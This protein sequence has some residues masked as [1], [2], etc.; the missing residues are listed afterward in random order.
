MFIFE[1]TKKEENFKNSRSKKID[2]LMIAI[3]VSIILDI[4]LLGIYGRTTFMTDFT[5]MF[6]GGYRIML[7][8]IPYQDFF[9]PIGPVSFAFLGLF[10][11]VFGPDILAS[12]LHSFF[13]V[14][15]LT[16]PFYFIVRKEFSIF[17][18]FIFSLFFYISFIG[19]S[20]HPLYNY[21][22]Y[23]FLFLNIFLILYHIKKDSLPMYVYILSAIL[24]TLDFYTKQD[25]GGIHL[26]LLFL[27][28]AVN[29]R[30]YWKKILCFYLIPSAMFVLGTFLILSNFEGFLYWYN[31]GQP[32]HATNF[33]KFFEPEKIVFIT[34][35]W[36]FYVGI[37]FIFL[38]LFGKIKNNYKKKIISL[39]LVI[40]ISHIVSNTLS[41]STRQLSVMGLPILIFFICLLLKD[42]VKELNP[43]NRSL[44][45]IAIILFLIVNVNPF[46]TYGL[47]AMNYL[48]PNLTRI[49]QGCFSGYLI[50]KE[51]ANGLQEIRSLIKEYPDFI[52]I[53]EDGFLYCDYKKEPPKKIPLCFREGT[54]F[55]MQDINYIAAQILSNNPQIILIQNHHGHENP[56][57]NN[58][59]FEIF[60][61]NGYEE[62][63][64]INKTSTSEAPIHIF[65]KKQ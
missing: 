41:G 26:F 23:F 52:S 63:Q 40:A 22:T 29:Y 15:T 6:E 53:T 21:T 50:T 12:M 30:K 39:F 62:R 59:F 32:P 35:S 1:E 37:I 19:L 7:G 18:S 45:N 48:N 33:S 28:F 46:P 44:F 49:N 25:T 58:K 51:A 10:Y 3:L 14:I 4:Q 31:Y 17:F 42:S 13:L 54:H 36:H 9:S 34:S 43:R 5:H 20:F 38:L 57:T 47:I 60:K 64:I 55:Y 16:I 8:Q 61:F 24:G 11:L 27:Y 56:D 65:I 2:I